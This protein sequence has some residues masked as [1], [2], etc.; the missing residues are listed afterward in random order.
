MSNIWILNRW[1]QT[2]SLFNAMADSFCQSATKP[3]KSIKAKNYKLIG[4]SY[5][6]GLECVDF[7]VVRASSYVGF[8]TA[9]LLGSLF[10]T[11][12]Y[13]RAI[14][15][16]L[17]M[18]FDTAYYRTFFSQIWSGETCLK[19]LRRKEHISCM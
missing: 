1:V 19:D 11:E 17:L 16:Y 18:G 2:V 6:S 3:L 8:L 9:K 7:F 12:C 13:Q 4:G 5:D 10:L 15:T 14:V